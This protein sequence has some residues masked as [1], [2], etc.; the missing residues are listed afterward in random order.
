VKFPGLGNLDKKV[1]DVGNE[2]GQSDPAVNTTFQ[3]QETCRLMPQRYAE[4]AATPERCDWM[5]DARRTMKSPA[6]AGQVVQ[7]EASM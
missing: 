5:I 7:R 2:T 4:T 6:G 3:V 1:C